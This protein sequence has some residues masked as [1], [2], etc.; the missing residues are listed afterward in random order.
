MIR[1]EDIVKIGQ[2]IKTHGT[3]GEI[4]FFFS[5]DSFDDCKHPF[6]ICEMEGIFVPF[7]LE[8]YRFNSAS[9]AFVK[10]KN[11]DS[12]EKAK[13]LIAKEVYFPKKHIKEDLDD[14]FSTWDYFTGFML[15]DENA[16]KIGTVSSVDAST[17]NTLFIV[18]K[19]DST[20]L[21]PAASELIVRI[22]KE[23]KKLYLNLPKGLLE[24]N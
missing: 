1:S 11:I 9:T 6:L 15:I 19:D 22:N 12:V 3:K 21:I 14:D 16:G 23:E 7:L 20:I 2:F 10:L 24:L 13:R 5:N 8:D 17:I 18:S 4:L